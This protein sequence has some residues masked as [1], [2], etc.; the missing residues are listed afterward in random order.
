MASKA[1][2]QKRRE[3][4]ER[5]LRYQASELTVAQFCVEEGVSTPSFYQCKR[6]LLVAMPS[7]PRARKAAALL[8]CGSCQ[9]PTSYHLVP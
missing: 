6:K 2:P 8:V 7:E 4:V 1:D 3:W 9:L 5:M